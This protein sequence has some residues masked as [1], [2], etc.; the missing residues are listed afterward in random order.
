MA[1]VLRATEGE[2][3]MG[4]SQTPT[5]NPDLRHLPLREEHVAAGA[6]FSPFG[7]WEMPLTYGSIIAEHMQVRTRA[8]LFDVSHM[9]RLLLRGP[10]ATTTV[11]GLVASDLSDLEVGQARYTVLLTPWGGIQDDLIVYRRDDGILLIVN[12]ARTTQD[13]EWIEGHLLASPALTPGDPGLELDDLTDLTC[14][15]ALQGPAA[16]AILDGLSP[17]LDITSMAPFSFAQANVAGVEVTVMRTGYTGETGAEVLVAAQDA[18]TLWNALLAAGAPGTVAPCGLGARDT[19]RLEAALLLYGQDIT[20]N[21]T[22]FEARLGW[23]T[24]LERPRQPEFVGRDALLEAA[25]RGPE[26]LLVGLATDA[27]TIPRHGDEIAV[28]DILVGRV[29]SGTH[30]PILGQP[31]ALGY[32]LPQHTAIGAEVVILSGEKEV[33]ARVVERPF[34]RAGVTPIPEARRGASRAE[35]SPKIDELA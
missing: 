29:T 18:R 7:G 13:R 25:E 33:A 14:L 30:S 3:Y 5:G 35:T 19:L 12:A 6:R 32:I 20:K 9:G 22:P 31:I 1:S 8:G 24:Q 11:Q 16:L 21:T 26:K 4:E 2:A 27:H 10:G 34:Y 15:L 17:G 28:G 23:L